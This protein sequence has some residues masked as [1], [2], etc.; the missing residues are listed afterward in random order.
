MKFFENQKK[1]M[2][3]SHL[4]GCV[5]VNSL[6]KYSFNKLLSHESLRHKF[7]SDIYWNKL[8]E[9]IMISTPRNVFKTGVY[10]SH[11]LPISSF[12]CPQNT[13]LFWLKTILKIM[14]NLI[15]Q[16]KNFQNDLEKI[17]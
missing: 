9:F 14:H 12:K 6:I 3:I 2:D 13:K 16:E 11:N 5:W 8:K 4:K 17:I 10:G 1:S 15:P 7:D